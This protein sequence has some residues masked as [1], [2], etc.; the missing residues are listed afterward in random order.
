[1][2]TEIDSGIKADLHAAIDA[3]NIE[4]LRDTLNALKEL[5]GAVLAEENVIEV[6]LTARQMKY[7]QAWSQKLSGQD[8]PSLMRMM[9]DTMKRMNPL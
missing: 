2:A 7:M 9:I 5:D 4:A 3:N 1:M 8:V 6:E